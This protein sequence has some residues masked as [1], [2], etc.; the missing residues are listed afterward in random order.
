MA[1]WYVLVLVCGGFCCLHRVGLFFWGSFN[2]VDCTIS[3]GSKHAFDPLEAA[4]RGEPRVELGD[5]AR[6]TRARARACVCA[7]AC[8]GLD[9]AN[10]QYRSLQVFSAPAQRCYLDA[11]ASVLLK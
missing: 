1:P 10:T 7:C 3:L 5:S 11:V 4:K 8:G 2:V 6:P 9:L